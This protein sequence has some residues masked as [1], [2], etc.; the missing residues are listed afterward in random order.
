M[1]AARLHRQM[2][3]RAG[4]RAC[5]RMSV[6]KATRCLPAHQ[7]APAAPA[8]APSSTALP[9][10][11][12]CFGLHVF[13]LELQRPLFPA[14][15]SNIRSLRLVPRILF[16]FCMPK[17]AFV[18]ACDVSCQTCANSATQCTVCSQWTPQVRLPIPALLTRQLGGV[19]I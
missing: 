15:W 10:L 2:S 5:L 11:R 3:S 9:A 4:L 14:A 13:T 17:C 12:E 8:Q 7:L 16:Q 6:C 18:A 19:P 1:A